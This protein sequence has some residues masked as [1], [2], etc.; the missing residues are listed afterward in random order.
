MSRELA[1]NFNISGLIPSMLGALEVLKA[2]NASKNIGS[3]NGDMTQL[4]HRRWHMI[5]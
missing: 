5:E 2:D 4:I 1:H 3:I